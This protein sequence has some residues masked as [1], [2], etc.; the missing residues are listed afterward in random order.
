MFLGVVGYVAEQMMSSPD[1]CSPSLLVSSLL[2]R[3]LDVRL[4]M[5]DVPMR[6]VRALVGVERLPGVHPPLLGRRRPRSGLLQ[7]LLGTAL[8][9]LQPPLGSHGMGPPLIPCRSAG[10]GPATRGWTAWAV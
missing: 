8:A 6:P 7:S 5:S 2:D 3:L 10:R 4:A 1:T 9:A